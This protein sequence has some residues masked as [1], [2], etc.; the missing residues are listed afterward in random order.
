MEAKLFDNEAKKITDK[1]K[2]IIK[3]AI[4]LFSEQGYAATSTREIARKAGAAEG[5]IFKL[6]PAKKD[7]FL[8]IIRKTI[9]TA[10]LPVISSGINKLKKKSFNSREDFLAAFLENSAELIQED[11][12]LFKILIQEIPFHPEIR[13]M[14]SEQLNKLPADLIAKKLILSETHSEYNESDI[15][16]LMISCI[17]VYI[18]FGAVSKRP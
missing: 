10:L 1:Q 16:N 9:N 14:L 6:F 7:L 12:L 5:S 8:W 17:A 3:T 4:E 2:L 18:L 13:A 15:I 11:D